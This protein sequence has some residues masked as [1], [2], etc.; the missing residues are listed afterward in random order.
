MTRAEFEEGVHSILNRMTEYIP[1]QEINHAASII[2][3]DYIKEDG[4]ADEDVIQKMHEYIDKPDKEYI[5]FQTVD[6][7]SIIK[8]MTIIAMNDIRKLAA[9]YTAAP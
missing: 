8:N 1:I 2:C 3:K 5:P 4:T 9:E 6:I 7:K